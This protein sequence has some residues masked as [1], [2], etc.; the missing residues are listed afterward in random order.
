M[1]DLEQS[2]DSASMADE[3]PVLD[4]STAT[5]SETQQTD[6]QDGAGVDAGTG[7]EEA[8]TEIPGSSTTPD[9]T[10]QT[11]QDKTSA[12]PQ[13]DWQ[14][15]LAKAEKQAADWRSKH[16]QSSNQ[17]HQYRQQ[18]DG[19]DAKTVKE[20]RSAQQ[21]AEQRNLPAWDRRNP[22]HQ[23]FQQTL[24]QFKTYQ[25]AMAK[26]DTPEKKALLQETMGS[27]FTQDQ[28]QQ[29]KAWDDHRG[30]FTEQFAMDPRGTIADIIRSEMRAEIE[31]ERAEVQA[32]DEVNG[33]MTADE[34]QPVVQKYGQQMLDA[35]KQGNQWPFVR[36]MA[37][38]R[39]RLEG[40]QSR[41]GTADKTT[42][43]ARA[44][45]DLRKKET[46]VT[47]DGRIKPQRDIAAEALRIGK[48]KGWS[49]N[50]GRYID[51]LEKLQQTSAI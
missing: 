32:N 29:I 24:S 2:S 48:E 25:S 12:A 11:T 14:A 39:A 38:D 46:V 40:L 49:S 20:W 34:N 22:A 21:L 44:Q 16:N 13:R 15:E 17:L 8:Q 51:L 1:N 23:G 28:A 37:L 3:T 9:T 6:T 31:N 50:D 30:Q 43:H 27:M 26:A 5:S 41:V 4:Q 45:S 18:Y 35:L 42:A 36:Q 7:S 47:K 10:S 19:V 33:W